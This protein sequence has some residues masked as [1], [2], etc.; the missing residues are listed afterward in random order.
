MG[1]ARLY[2]RLRKEA[3]VEFIP[4]EKRMM[5]QDRS[6]TLTHPPGSPRARYRALKK[7]ARDG[8]R[9]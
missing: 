3:G 9:N 1:Q 8:H 7:E 2:K 6:G 5:T 4:Y